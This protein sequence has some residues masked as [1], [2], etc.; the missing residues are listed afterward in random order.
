MR[1][2]DSR[3]KIGVVYIEKK[4]RENHLRWF[5]QVRRRATDASIRRV[6]CIYLGQV[7]RAQGRPKKTWMEVIRQDIEAKRLSEDILLDRNEWRKLIHVP[8]RALFSF[9]SCSLP[10]I[11]GTNGLVVVVA[12]L[13]ALCSP[14]RFIFGCEF[15]KSALIL[16]HL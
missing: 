16:F 10:Q 11:L 14:S 5:D 9:D 13:S 15:K 3:T 4:M 8:D 1:N 12:L 6:E 2:E 7:K